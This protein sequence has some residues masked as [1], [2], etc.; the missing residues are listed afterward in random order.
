MFVK[1]M[2]V[3]VDLDCLQADHLQL[4]KHAAAKFLI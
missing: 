2:L 1:S 4:L 3:N